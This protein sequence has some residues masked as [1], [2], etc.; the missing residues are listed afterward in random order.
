D[1]VAV[2]VEPVSDNDARSVIPGVVAVRVQISVRHRRA[3]DDEV[4]TGR[5]RQGGKGQQGAVSLEIR[6]AD[7]S[8]R[9]AQGRRTEAGVPLRGDGPGSGPVRGY[10][11]RG[12]RRTSGANGPSEPA[13]VIDRSVRWRDADL[14]PVE[15]RRG[16][17]CRRDSRF[18][19][20]PGG[21]R[22]DENPLPP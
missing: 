20:V 5:D 14:S 17:P 9:A 8:R 22:R 11:E 6:S 12:A 7:E 1:R 16:G 2:R 21:R 10:R 4:G 3:S 13:R 19:V 18:D 15:D